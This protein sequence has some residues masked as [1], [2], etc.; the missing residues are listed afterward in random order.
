[1]GPRP[2]L[3]VNYWHNVNGAFTLSVL[4][5]PEP[6]LEKMGCLMKNVPHYT[7]T[8]TH[9][10]LLCWSRSQSWFQSRSKPVWLNHLMLKRSEFRRWYVW[11]KLDTVFTCNK[12]QLDVVMNIP[13]ITD[14]IRRMREGNVFSLSTPVGGGGT[15]ARSSQGVPHLGYPPVR[16]GLGGGTPPWVP[17]SRTWPGGYPCQKGTPLSIPHWTWWGGT[18]AGRGVPHL[19]NPPSYLAGG[20]PCQEG[21]PPV[22]PGQGYPCWKGVS[23]IRPGL[24]GTPA[25]G[26]Y[27]P[28]VTD[29]VLDTPRSVCLL[30]SHRRTFLLTAF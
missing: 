17:P 25:G 6:G 12:L 24:G 22:K 5:T 23:P 8:R 20:Y 26:G 13:V 9:C 21:V 2:I 4:G 7:G 10:F 16:P 29:G 15:P 18:P 19:G 1:M 14:R 11:T 28:Q 27:P 30:R 3:P